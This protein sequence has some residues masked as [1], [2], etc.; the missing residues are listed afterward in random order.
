MCAGETR[1][2]YA[3]GLKLSREIGTR[4]M[5][6]VILN[7]LGDTHAAVGDPRAAHHAWR[8]ALT[9]LTDL[10]HPDAAAVRA[11]LSK[12]S[13]LSKLSRPPSAGRP[14]APRRTRPAA[15]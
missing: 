14:D 7:R 3:R 10:A 9:I 15:P 8:D 12:V 2:R 5:E 13:K 4:R 11:K 1:R 6:A